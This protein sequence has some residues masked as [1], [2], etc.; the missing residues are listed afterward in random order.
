ME[1]KEGR[2]EETLVVCL[3]NF[4]PNVVCVHGGV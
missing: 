1:Q 2:R 3:S 4:I